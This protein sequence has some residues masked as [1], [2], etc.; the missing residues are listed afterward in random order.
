ME[1]QPLRSYRRKDKSLGLL[2]S[3]FL[4]LYNRDSVDLISLD[5]AAAKLGV[6]RRRIYDVVNILETIGLVARR[7]KSQY[8]WMGFGA[9]PRVLDQLKEQGMIEKIGIIPCVTNTE[10]VLYE[11]EREESFKLTLH[12]QENSSTYLKLDNNKKEK[13]LWLLSQNFLKLFLCSYDDLIALDSVTKALLGETQDPINRKTKIRR[14]YDIANVFSSLRLI[15][16]THMPDSKKAAYRWLGF[17]SMSEN[18]L[19][20]ASSP[21]LGD[22]NESENRLIVSGSS[23]LGDGFR[24]TA[25][26]SSSLGDGNE[27]E[28][29]LIAAGS[30]SLGDGNESENRL[31]VAASASLGDGKESKMRLFETEL[32]KL[33][34]KR[35]KRYRFEDP[36]FW[37]KKKKSKVK[38]EQNSDSNVAGKS[39]ASGSAT[40]T[41]DNNN[42]GRRLGRLAEIEALT[43][44]Y[45]PQYINPVIYGLFGHFKD[46]MNA[47]MEEARPK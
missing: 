2:V 39:S 4:S 6:E 14:L 25:A 18:S 37:A 21:T 34:A 7:G 43:S 28:N 8:S 35:S 10:M 38:E 26:G 27:S 11:Q 41:A 15:E 23:S 3:N 31:I 33:E 30:S 32:S 29:K 1:A 13:I 12:D 19:I 24:L 42:S 22:G 9:V 44:T 40:P 20:A 46:T 45:R 16:K 5:D 17:E 36:E 47:W